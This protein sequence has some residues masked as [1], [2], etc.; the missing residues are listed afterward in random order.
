MNIA[1]FGGTFDPVHRGHL[2]VARAAVRQFGLGQLYFV[3]ASVPPHKQTSPAA[4]FY[5]R[6]AMLALA[7]AGDKKL[8]PSLLE[9][10]PD[11]EHGAIPITTGRYPTK[12]GA[13]YSI[14]TVRRVKGLL[15][16]SDR[17]FFLTGVDS[18]RKIATWREPE[19]L[20]RECEFIV[21]S[22]PGFS[23]ADVA[24]SLPPSMRPPAHIIKPF[25]RQGAR[26]TMVHAGATIHLLEEVHENVS[27]TEVR[28]AIAR[29]SSLVK[30]LDPA[31]A[32]YI[33]KLHL[34]NAARAVG[35]SAVAVPG[36]TKRKKQRRSKT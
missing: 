10:P 36:S 3:P 16:K 31:V 21:A 28:R 27:A 11:Y 12:P 23:L 26:G 8:L 14:D 17:L 20:L 24:N 22:R 5:H 19:A 1:L 29:G 33:K 2:A 4:S 30:L 34:Y 18:F 9:A 7:T 13:N 25:S 15:K 32:A 6:F 35:T